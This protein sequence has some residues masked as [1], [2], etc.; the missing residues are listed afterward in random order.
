MLNYL[1]NTISSAE[2]IMYFNFEEENISLSLSPTQL[3]GI[4]KLLGIEIDSTGIKMFSDESLKSF[5]DKT[6]NNWK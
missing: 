5:L 1:N 2:L 4:I 6:I 3:K